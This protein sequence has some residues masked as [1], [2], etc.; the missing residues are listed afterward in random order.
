MAKK[1]KLGKVTQKGREQ[2]DN[3]YSLMHRRTML[4]TGDAPLPTNSHELGDYI[5]LNQL[6]EC[7]IDVK[8]TAK[9]V[10]VK[11]EAANAEKAFV[12][13]GRRHQMRLSTHMDSGTKRKRDQNGKFPD[14]PAIV[15][16]GGGL[17]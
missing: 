14:G 1:M 8:Y 15:M 13:Q 5:P 3:V 10:E 4:T 12:S 6:P 7:V 9:G 16:S 17:Y 11:K 2:S